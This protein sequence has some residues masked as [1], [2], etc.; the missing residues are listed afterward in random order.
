ME[1]LT[2]GRLVECKTALAAEAVLEA[3]TDTHH[4]SCSTTYSRFPSLSA[5]TVA[6]GGLVGG[7]TQNFVVEGLSLWSWCLSQAMAKTA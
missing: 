5:S 4:D 3:T 6:I 1:K 2:R 7:V